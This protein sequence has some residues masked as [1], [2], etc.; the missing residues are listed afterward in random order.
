MC[1]LVAA[2]LIGV[3]GNDRASLAAFDR[4]YFDYY[5]YIDGLIGFEDLSTIEVLEVGLGYGS[6]SQRIAESGARFTGLDIAAGPVAGVAHRLRQSGLAGRAFQGSILDPPFADAS[7]D[8]IVS[9]G[10]YHHT[11]NLA[12]ALA[13]TARLQRPNGRAT[14]MVYNATSYIQWLRRP[15]QTWT[16]VR[17]VANGDDTPLALVAADDRLDFDADSQ[18]PAPP[19]TVAVSKRHFERMLGR[20]FASVAVRRVN[21]IAHRPIQFMPRS[22][23]LAT[24]GPMLGFDLYAKISSP[25]RAK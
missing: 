12:K 13:E 18:G 17:A 11:G 21:A 1:G 23:M 20:H 10:C 5:P 16:H 7:S 3:T 2:R 19:E 15:H 22:V 25:I 9:I 4:W 14:L 8:V 24:V 6:V